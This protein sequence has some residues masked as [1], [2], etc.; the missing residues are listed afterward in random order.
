MAK[1]E[2]WRAVLGYERLYEVSNMGRVRSLT[3]IVPHSR[4]GKQIIYGRVLRPG[5]SSG[6]YY[7]VCLRRDGKAKTFAVYRLVALAFCPRDSEFLEVRH[8]DGDQKN[9]KASNLK[10]GTRSENMNDR[11]AHGT[12]RN[13]LKT[14]CPQ[15]HEYRGENLRFTAQGGRVCK[16]CAV[17]ATRRWREKNSIEKKVA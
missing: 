10:W 5:V 14:H 4:Y 8:L 16:S 12:D 9:D 13:V 11:I 17:A 1:G 15:G 2:V 3:R 7:S 6:G